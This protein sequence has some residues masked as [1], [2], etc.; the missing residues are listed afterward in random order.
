M[1]DTTISHYRIIEKLGGG[2]MGVVYKDQHYGFHGLPILFATTFLFFTWESS[3]RA[4]SFPD[5]PLAHK[6]ASE[7]S[8]R[9][10]EAAMFPHTVLLSSGAFR[11]GVVVSDIFGRG[12]VRGTLEYTIDWLPAVVITKPAVIYCG[13]VAPVGVRWNI[14]AK[15]C[16]HPYGEVVLGGVLCHGNIPPSNLNI[17]FTINSGVGLTL[18]TRGNQMLTAGLDYSH[19]SNADLGKP[20]PNYNGIAFVLEYHWL[21][22]EKSK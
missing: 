3:V 13:G 15:P 6:D 2:G 20:N 19:L 11:L 22:P 14:L 4:Q 5:Y 17:G 1:I 9:L 16:L 21:K 10:S 8:I 18:F 12:W 7:V